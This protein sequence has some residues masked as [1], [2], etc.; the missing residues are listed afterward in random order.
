MMGAG[1]TL[2]FLSDFYEPIEAWRDRVSA[3]AAAGA[4]GALVMIADP[5]EED[6][7]FQGRMLFN[8]PGS[9]REAL[10]GRAENARADYAAR[11]EQHRR[12]IHELGAKLGF[13]S[14]LHRTDH[15]AAPTLALL[16]ALISERFA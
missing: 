3:A 2:I 9:H 7:P 15:S 6:F 1:S 11:L 8:E 4:T 10:I 5:A 13:P 12:D 14:L 16:I